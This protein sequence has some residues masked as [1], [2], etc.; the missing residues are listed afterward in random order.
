[1]RFWPFYTFSQEKG[2]Q[3]PRRRAKM[4]QENTGPNFKPGSETKEDKTMTQ[5]NESIHGLM[6]FL[7]KSPS[8]FHAVANLKQMLLDE[9]FEELAE[10]RSV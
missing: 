4:N 1:M 10:T 3:T 6:E 9:G 5:T 7:K 8:A 2:L